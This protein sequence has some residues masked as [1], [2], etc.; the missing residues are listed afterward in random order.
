MEVATVNGMGAVIHGTAED[1]VEMIDSTKVADGQTTAMIPLN[2]RQ[3]IPPA[4]KS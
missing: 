2:R 1:I 4:R 3:V